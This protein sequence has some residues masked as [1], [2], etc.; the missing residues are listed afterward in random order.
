MKQEVSLLKYII[1]AVLFFNIASAVSQNRGSLDYYAQF[2]AIVSDGNYAPYWLTAN[3]NGVSSVDANSGYARYAMSYHNA[4]GKNDNFKY[5]ITADILA[6]YNQPSEFFVQ[7]LYG[8]ISWKWLTLS[9]GSKERTGETEYFSRADNNFDNNLARNYRNLFGDRFS[10]LGSGGLAYSGNSRPVPQMRIEV[11]EYV[12]IPGTNDWLRVRGYIAY[13]FFTDGNYQRD[14]TRANEKAKYGTDILYHAKAG[15]ISIGKPSKFPLTFEG[16]LEMHAQFGGTMYKTGYVHPVKM[17][18]G[19]VDFLKAFI[20]MGGSDDTPT[21]EQTNISGNQIG[22]WHAAFTYHSSPFEVRLYGEH[23]FEDFSQLFFFEYQMNK[24][25]KRRVL[26]YPWRD[27]LVGVN[28]RNKSKILPFV[29]NIRY[30]YLT[31]RDQ[32]GALYHDPSDYFND[33][34]DG[35]DNYYNHGIYPGWHHW[36][37]GMGNPLIFSPAYNNNGSLEFKGN[38]LVA[39]NVGVNGVFSSRLP[40]AYRLNYTYSE[41]WG[42]YYNPFREKKYTTSLLAEATFLPRKAGWTGTVAVGYDKSDFIGENLGVLFTFT[43]S[44]TFFN[45]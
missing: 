32:S 30:E 37:M 38:R 14:F 12:A 18:H 42:T 20:P 7:Q 17:P 13:G 25:G 9:L 8:E 3:R 29:S 10:S 24:D 33:Q 15:F 40:I 28:I 43:Y 4:F 27:I 6:G 39:H 34:L 16:G 5:R 44:G 41:N 31:T 36:G 2:N 19:F 26:V 22:S 1:S 23:L 45:K 21:V 35:C 11:P